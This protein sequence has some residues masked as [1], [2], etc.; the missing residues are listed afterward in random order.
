MKTLQNRI[1]SA[2]LACALALTLLFTGASAQAAADPNAV[3]TTATVTGV[4]GR[5]TVFQDGNSSKV[6]KGME[7][8]VG[9]TI[10]T[11]L[12]TVTLN[13]GG[14][15]NAIV[16]SRSTLTIEELSHKIVGGETQGNTKFDLKKGILLGNVKKTT[17][18]SNYKV[19]TAKGVAGIRG[20]TYEIH[21]I[22][23]FKCGEGMFTVQ[24]LVTGPDGAPQVI[25]LQSATQLDAQAAVAVVLNLTP[26]QAQVVN[27]A[28]NPLLANPN[29]R[30]VILIPRT[31]IET[32]IT[33]TVGK[34]RV[35]P[36]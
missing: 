7:I 14:H 19:K 33:G 6:K 29:V 13:L 24:L 31:P 16:Q 18:A 20:T 36:T 28:V 15:G 23:I 26:A 35:D 9:A 11:G 30:G 2:A 4:T 5:A 21:A 3:R 12:G 22:G 1:G 10:S 17:A 34:P 25:T 8:G 32:T 27:N